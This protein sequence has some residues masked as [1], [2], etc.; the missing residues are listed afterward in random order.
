MSPSIRPR[1]LLPMLTA[2]LWIT[3]APDILAAEA[4]RREEAEEPE[5]L[6]AEIRRHDALYFGRAEPE[7][8]DAEY[9]RLQ[10]R[11]ARAKGAPA[12]LGDD[13]SPDAPAHAHAAPML[14]LAKCHAR[15]QLDAFV[16]GIRRRHPD[17]AF[18]IEPKYDGLAISVT[19]EHGRLTRA[20]TRGDGRRGE[21]VTAALRAMARLPAALKPDT[22]AAFPALVE[23]RGEAYMSLAEFRTINRERAEAGEAPYA[24][25][26]NLAVGTLK[27][28]LEAD[29]N[30]RLEVVFYGIGATADGTAPQSQTQWLRQ[31]DAWGLPTA[32]APARA[33]DEASVWA[34]VNALARRRDT[35]PY[36]VDGAVVK[37]DAFALRRELGEG[38]EA[39]RWAVAYKFAPES[40]QTRLRAITFTLGRTGAL[41][42]VAE[43]DAV[44]LGGASVRRATLHNTHEIT[45]R[46]L[47]IGD[48]ITVE[49][50]GDI[51]PA[52]TA[53][54]PE[55][56]PVG[57]VAFTPP[58]HC[59]CC[60]T[61]L[62]PGANGADPVCANEA[63]GDRIRRAIEHFAS[64]AGVGI[65]GLGPALV[66]KLVTAGLVTTPADLYRLERTPLMALPGVGAT[67]ADRLLAAIAR[68]KSVSPA[69]FLAALGIP[70]IGAGAARKITGAFP[71]LRD[72]RAASPAAIRTLK[73][74]PAAETALIAYLHHEQQR[75]VLDALIRAGCG[76]TGEPG[77]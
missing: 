31:I 63:C 52:V 61:R 70:E 57:S 32:D 27:G 38:A 26:R 44:R 77:K 17:A 53:V 24:H 64:P 23:L 55:K 46:D 54:D 37:V 16:S 3:A 69:K 45:R 33:T 36:P 71:D 68:S 76:A 62:Q 40:A 59:P 34:A 50:A 20:L 28:V 42:P 75:G 47:R 25:P 1:T 4:S 14:G 7:I 18:V 29:G 67:S 9:D 10:Q 48:L 66:D 72:L 49:K 5:R 2:A 74:T 58:T 11:L 30:R 73:L 39:P 65:K 35:L 8:S 19:Y 15:S 12:G 56:R 21:D 22:N 60:A 6:R 43:F 51:I 41:T 13:A